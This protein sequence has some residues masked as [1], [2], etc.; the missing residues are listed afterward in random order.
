[1]FSSAAL[2]ALANAVQPFAVDCTLVS[3]T[4]RTASVNGHFASVEIRVHPQAEHPVKLHLQYPWTRGGGS[5]FR[6]CHQSSGDVAASRLE[7]VRT[8]NGNARL[9]ARIDLPAGAL[10]QASLR[11]L[12]EFPVSFWDAE[13]GVGPNAPAVAVAAT[14]RRLRCVARNLQVS[15]DLF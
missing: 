7:C 11:T 15:K 9:V 6:E 8:E 10:E 14:E 13:P 4:A 2:L 12:Q 3:S 5:E 1:M